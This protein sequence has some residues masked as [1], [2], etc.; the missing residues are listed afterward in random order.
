MPGQPEPPR[1]LTASE[2]AD[3]LRLTRWQVVNLCR[4]G[5]IRATKPF[6]QWLINPED[7]EA[8]ID[9][10]FKRDRGAA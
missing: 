3:I 9:A 1:F 8:A 2:A 4:D 10:G 6:K 7:L 5:K